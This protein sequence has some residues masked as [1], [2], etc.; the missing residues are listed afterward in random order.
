MTGPCGSRAL[1]ALVVATGLLLGPVLHLSPLEPPAHELLPPAGPTTADAVVDRS[2]MTVAALV[3]VPDPAARPTP[4]RAP[5]PGHVASDAGLRRA[6]APRLVRIPE[7]GALAPVEQVGVLPDGSMEIPDDIRVVGW[8][9]TAHRSVGPGDPGTAVI[10]GH[11]DSRAQGRGALHGLS[12]LEVGSMIE[13]VHADDRVSRWQVDR[14]LT[15]PRDAL[16]VDVLFAR[17]GSPRLA[18]VTCGGTFD[19][20]TRSYSHNTIVLARLI[21]D[22]PDAG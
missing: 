17:E 12:R 5:G 3:P 16:P 4:G 7:L 6:A 21:D 14:M 20:R 2:R 22:G 8:Y 11:L 1:I 10:A 13:I 9:A 19:A 15:T 18:L